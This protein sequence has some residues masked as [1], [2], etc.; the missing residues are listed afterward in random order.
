MFKELIEKK[1][2]IIDEDFV[3]FI[4]EEKVIDC[5]IGYEFFFL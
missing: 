1:K 2:E 3:F 5:K 4:L